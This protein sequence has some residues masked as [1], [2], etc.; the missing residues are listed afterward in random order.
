MLAE[1]GLLEWTFAGI[2][3]GLTG[4]VGVAFLYMVGTLFVNPGRRKRSV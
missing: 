2:L 4:A 1:W 3:V